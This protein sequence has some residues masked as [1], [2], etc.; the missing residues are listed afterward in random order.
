MNRKEKEKN[1]RLYLRVSEQE[2]QKITELAH[3]C[4]LSIAEYLRKRALGYTVKAVAPDAFYI[5]NEKMSE[6]LNRDLSP[7]IESAALEL[8]DA[9]YEEIL[10]TPKQS[11]K[12]I[13]QEV[14]RWQV[15]DSGPLSPD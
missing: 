15:P 3:C 4:D 1:C 9:L 6:L 12:K 13:I 10:D 5:F 14:K 11:R 7:E 8:F 2:K